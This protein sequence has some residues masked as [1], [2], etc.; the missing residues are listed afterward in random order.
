MYSTK[1]RERDPKISAPEKGAPVPSP[2]LEWIWRYFRDVLNPHV[3]DCGTGSSSTISVLLNR[4]AKIYV[5]DLIAPLQRCDPAYWRQEDKEFVFCLDK[6][7]A[8]LPAIPPGSL[9]LIYVW[10]LL[11]LLPG[12]RVPH[13]LQSMLSLLAP[14]G[15]FFCFLRESNLA[16]GSA[17]R[18]RLESL[19]RLAGENADQ[20]KFRYPV[21]ANRDVERLADGRSVKTFLTRA[22]RREVVMLKE[23]GGI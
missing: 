6:F 8:L 16:F 15:V 19:T 7:L 4:G 20:G 12:D 1:T 3:L 14:G 22:H 5:G 17:A 2:A 21:L 9:S 23:E 10:H 13:L 18:W 11:D